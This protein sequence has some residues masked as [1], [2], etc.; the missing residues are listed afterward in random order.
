M[1]T[2]LPFVAAHTAEE[3]TA[4]LDLSGRT[5]LVTGCNS[6]LGHETCRVLALRGAR[7]VGAARSEAKAQAALDGLGIDGIA[8]A[9]DLADLTSVQAAV[10]AVRALAPLDG[11][12][13]NAGVM[14]VQ[15]L[16]LVRGLE[17]QFFTN[18]IGHFT[19]VTGLLDTLTETGR[20]VMLS[21]G[22]HRMAPEAGIDFDNL[23]G[24]K[25][26]NP[27]AAY[28]RS[29][30]ANLLFARSLTR[31]LA[32]S[33]RTANA[34]HPGVIDTNLGRHVPNKEAMYQQL[35][36]AMKTVPQ[37]ASTQCLVATHPALDDVSGAYFADNQLAPTLHARAEDDDLAEA[38]W[39]KSEA[40]VAEALGR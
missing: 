6:G 32:G 2:A 7:I 31:R 35:A 36:A 30:L 37:G 26:Y 4:G 21:S 10:D 34:V 38:L 12:V 29:K 22:A 17:A 19:L 18:H 16:R 5:Y 24:E 39:A 3:V 40:I 11:I 28:G 33:G 15:E 1:M 13:A 14:A 9:C 20:V 23:A 25:G 27:W 8:V